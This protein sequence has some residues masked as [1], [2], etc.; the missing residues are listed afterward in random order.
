MLVVL[1]DRGVLEAGEAPAVGA[2]AVTCFCFLLVPLH[3]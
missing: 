3:W 2:F 1:G